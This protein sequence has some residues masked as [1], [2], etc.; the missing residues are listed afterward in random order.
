MK[1]FVES[2]NSKSNFTMS[3]GI[4]KNN[5]D[6]AEDGR[7]QIYIPS[8]DSK[9][10]D[11]EDLTWATY[12]SPFGGTVANLKVGREKTEIPGMSSYG[13][14]AIPKIGAQV[15]CGFLESDPSSRFWFGCI[16]VPEAN[17]T[18]LILS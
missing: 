5:A 1:N 18:M 13:F 7:L 14:W 16:Y 17:R 15:I 11:L 6:P 10:Y 3:I 9:S 4:V 8:I 12:V 2:S